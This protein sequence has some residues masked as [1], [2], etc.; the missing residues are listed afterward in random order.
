MI[1]RHAIVVYYRFPKLVKTLKKMGNLTYFNRKRNYAILY[2]DAESKD[3][4][5]QSIK[6]LKG[7]KYVDESYLDEAMYQFELNV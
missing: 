3:S 4:I 2:V 7:V 1:N 6:G 5:I